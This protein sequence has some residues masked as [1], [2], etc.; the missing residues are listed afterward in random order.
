MQRIG[1]VTGAARGIGSAIA[2]KIIAHVDRLI[3]IDLDRKLMTELKISLMSSKPIIIKQCDIGSSRQVNKMLEA[4]IEKFGIPNILINNAGI[5]GPFHRVDQVTDK[6]WIKIIN[7]NLKGLF[8]LCRFLL[9]LM[10]EMHY[11]RI[12]NIAST[13]GYLGAALSSTYVAS[14]HG[15]VGYTRAIAAEWGAYGITC[16]AVCPGYVDTSMGVQNSISD[17]E[18]KIIAKTPLA[19]IALPDEIADLVIHLIKDESAFINGSIIPI[20]GGLT[21]HVGI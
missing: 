21:C 9:P 6:E 11:G 20:D 16:N 1:L 17:H 5:G 12:V 14:K 4:V 7:T 18:K 8:N 3:L 13:Q 15:V 19:R 10:K 2:R